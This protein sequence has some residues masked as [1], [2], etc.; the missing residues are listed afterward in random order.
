MTPSKSLKVN[1]KLIQG[2]MSIKKG[3]PIKNG[4]R[5]IGLMFQNADNPLISIIILFHLCWIY[6]LSNVFFFS[7]KLS[8]YYRQMVTDLESWVRLS[9]RSMFCSSTLMNIIQSLLKTIFW[10]SSSLISNTYGVIGT[11]SITRASWRIVIFFSIYLLLI[12]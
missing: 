2:S 4:Y 7:E 1:G 9:C 3:N 8:I 5:Y 6:D 12:G 11:S 10:S